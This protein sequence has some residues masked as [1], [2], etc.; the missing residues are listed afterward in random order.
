VPDDHL[1]FRLWERSHQF[2]LTDDL[3]FHVFELP[4]FTKKADDLR[5]RMEVWLY[6][7]RHA[8]MMD[9]DLLP[10]SL[11][12]APVLRAFEE[13]KMLTQDE[14]ERERYESRLKA[15]LD[16]QT[17]L[18]AARLDGIEEGHRVGREEGR[19]E[20]HK[21]GTIHV[22]QRLLNRP[23]TPT[24]ELAALPLHELTRLEEELQQQVT[25]RPTPNGQ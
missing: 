6:F 7:L 23:E 20:G 18:S 3:E 22:Y 24:R 2:A 8:A 15:Q 10:E 11:R 16:Y 21:I 25:N 13:L 19:E 14:L 5:N 12:V 9:M 1:C 4:K 17:G